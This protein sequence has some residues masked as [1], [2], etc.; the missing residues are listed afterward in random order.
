MNRQILS[1]AVLTAIATSVAVGQDSGYP[2]QP[3][4]PKILLQPENQ[5]VPIGSNAVFFVIATNGPLAYQWFRNGDPM[6]EQT[7]E[8]LAISNAQVS[9]VASY[10]CDIYRGLEMVPTR[11]AS[12]MVFTSS[13]DPQTGV[14]PVVVY[15]SPVYGSG[16]QGTCPGSSLG[17]V[18]YT[19]TTQQGWG[20]APDT[21]NGNTL[22]TATDTNRTNTNIQFAGAYG[23]TGCNTTT[24]T[25][26]NPPISPVYEF[27]IFFTNNVPTNPYA[28]TLNGFKP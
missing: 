25:V 20:W 21:S 15:G 5:L 14:D 7:N 4:F 10:S 8:T 13:I 23:D 28:I 16:S 18:S 22:F 9:D 19:K 2:I 3:D 6:N 26:P 27:A 12:L 17:H 1:F 11:A 24:V